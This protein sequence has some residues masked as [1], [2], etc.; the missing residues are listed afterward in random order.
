MKILKEFQEKNRL[1]CDIE[2]LS[3]FL[4]EKS[5]LIEN[6]PSP[7][8]CLGATHILQ[9]EI[10]SEAL[11]IAR[12]HSGLLGASLGDHRVVSLDPDFQ[13]ADV[14]IRLARKFI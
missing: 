7:I 5:F 14:L 4:V 11:S 1:E 3:D 13:L 2:A 6:S 8:E 12:T 9:S 10:G